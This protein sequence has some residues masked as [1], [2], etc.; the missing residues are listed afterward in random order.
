MAQQ[1]PIAE[2]TVKALSWQLLYS[3]YSQALGGPE[4]WKILAAEVGAP[5]FRHMDSDEDTPMQP[6]NKAVL[7]IDRV[8]GSGDGSKIREITRASVKR[9]ANI[10]KNLVNQLQSRPQKMLEIF[11]TEVHPYFLNDPGA[12]SIVKSLPNEF[13]L[14]LDNALLEEFKVGLLEGFVEIIGGKPKIEKRPDATYRVTWEILKEAPQPSRVA[15]FIN[16]T[17]LPFLTA[18]AVPILLGTAIAWK[19]GFGDVG[20][21]LLTLLGAVFFQ[22]G[23]NV[24]ND[25]FDHKNGV[26]EANFTPGPFSG[27]SRVIQRGLMQP[28]A[29]RNLAILFYAAGITIGLFLAATRGWEL[30]IF[31]GLGFLLGIFYVAPPILLSHRG[32]GE[33]AVGIGFGPLMVVGAYFVQAQRWSLEALYASLPIALLIAAVLYINE[34]PDRLW[35]GRAGKNTLVVRLSWERAIRGYYLLIAL[36]YFLIAIG[37]LLS[38]LPLATIVALFTI[39]LA[40]KASQVLRQNYRFPYRLIPANAYTIF[41]HLLTGLLLFYAYIADR[42]I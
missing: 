25:Y 2:Q 22:L 29:V 38:F 1:K 23:T 31:G 41:V 12:S 27:G 42:L 9:W 20:L 34:F 24:I 35:D 5:D 15:L 18:T 7:Y 28:Q 13:I 16:A 3:N 11:C 40:W 33:I 39:P 8:V 17:R 37:T 4:G 6:F 30:V 36:V 26:D 32:V 19:D 14:R 21:F 10:F